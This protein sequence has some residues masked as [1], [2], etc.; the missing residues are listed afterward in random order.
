MYDNLFLNTELIYVFTVVSEEKSI[1]KASVL[2]HMS[3]PAT[4]KKVKQ[5]EKILCTTLFYRSSKGVHLTEDGQFLYKKSKVF[6]EN[7]RDFMRS[8]QSQISLN[9]INIGCLDSIS[10]NLL[11]TFFEQ[12]ISKFKSAKITTNIFELIKTFNTYQTNVVIMDSNFGNNLK[13]SFQEKTLY[14]E[15][16]YVVYDLRNSK[17]NNQKKLEL[18]IQEISQFNWILYPSYCPIH[19]TLLSKLKEKN[20]NKPQILEIDHSDSISKFI[21]NTEFLTILPHSQAIRQVTQNI[22]R[23]GMKKVNVELT[24]NISIFTR[25]NNELTSFAETIFLDQKQPSN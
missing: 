15:P 24:R 17:L 18:T 7:T 25:N 8:V 9:D 21:Y 19:Q 14:S 5:L 11:S 2:L 16:Y 12:N 4:S 13:N 3:Q 20:I 1:N 10:A 6:L 23:L 22:S